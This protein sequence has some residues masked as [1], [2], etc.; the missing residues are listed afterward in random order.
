MIKN[1]YFFLLL[2]FLVSN[3]ISAQTS[4]DTLVVSRYY[5]KADSLLLDR[6]HEESIKLFKQTLPLYEKAMVWEKVASCYNK[7][8]E[9]Y[10]KN[11]DY[12][13]S[14]I[15][16]KLALEIIKKYLPKNNKEEAN[17]YDNMGKCYEK[18]AFYKK[19]LESFEL[20]LKIRQKL[21]KRQHPDFAK[22][23]HSIAIC[24]YR[25]DD[26]NKTIEY[27]KKALEINIATRGKYHNNNVASYN[28]LAIMTRQLGDYNLGLEYCH[29]ALEVI[30]NNK[31]KDSLY[32]SGVYNTIA[33]LYERIGNLNKAVEYSDKSLQIRKKLYD[34]HPKLAVS[35]IINGNLLAE[36]EEYTKALENMD[37]AQ[38]IY[39]NKFGENHP[40]TAEVLHFKG[41]I[42]TKLNRYSDA[43]DY[44]KSG[45]AIEKKY[46]GE[47]HGSTITSYQNIG[48]AYRKK[49]EMIFSLKYY[50]KALNIYTNT[51]GENHPKV[52]TILNDIGEL[53]V[54]QEKIDT[55][56]VYFF[57]AE[58]A[59]FSNSFNPED[60][61]KRE[62]SFVDPYVLLTTLKG[63][64]KCLQK[65]SVENSNLDSLERSISTYNR[66][67]SLINSISKGINNYQDKL[68]FT[69]QVQEIYGSS[70]GSYLIQYRKTG[71]LKALES[72][73]HY[74][75]KSKARTL[76]QILIDDNYKSFKQ[77]PEKL[78][79]LEKELRLNHSFYT[80]RITN[81]YSDKNTDT[82]AIA[83]YE[84]LLF[85]IN[86]KQDS[87]TK[88]FETN[89]PK[90]Y[91]LKYKNEVI[92]LANVQKKLDEET[93][94]LEF[95]VAN[96]NLYLFVIS[97]ND[98]AVQELTIPDLSKRISELNHSIINK[99]LRTY[100]ESSFGLYNE[101]IAPI[102]ENLVGDQ[103]IIIPDGPLWHLNFDLLLTESNTAKA[104]DLPYLLFDY[105]VSY[106]N[107]T[108]LLFN[109]FPTAKSTKIRKACL[110]FSFSDTTGLTNT[111]SVS[112]EKLR[113]STDDLPGTRKE[114]RAIS[115]IINGQY[116]YGLEAVE[117]NFKQNADRFSILHLALHGEVDHEHPQN[118][119]LYFTKNKD[120][121]E[122]NLLY[123]HELFAMDIPADLAVLSACNTGSGTIAKG[124]GIMSLGNAFQYA[125]TKSVL[126]S[127]WDVSDKSAPVLIENFYKN[128]ANNMN[129]A[130]AL[131]Q[132]KV[133]F[134]KTANFEQ[135]APFYWGNFYLLGNSDPIEIDKPLESHFFWIILGCILTAFLVL[136]YRYYRKN[137]S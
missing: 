90:Y 124:E 57:K 117:S 136:A 11:S 127:S 89:Y 45:L 44:L 88:I 101:L 30:N 94:V 53:Y 8:S 111:S 93:T 51:L 83:K 121:V 114:I 4:N 41:N 76:K 85:D 21:Y 26:I 17:A 109:D 28:N 58:K 29:K 7:I 123:N 120:T 103:L 59:N 130:K 107:S 81:E 37:Q 14:N 34:G 9:N 110:A 49:G 10:W 68:A 79:G 69:K 31:K 91:D 39:A 6:K 119:K 102:R 84:N 38:K 22:S 77:L 128:L 42:F 72:A 55:A 70:I 54:D 99:N 66:I 60:K 25:T 12:V 97:K 1:S 56:L 61:N 108:S 125:G 32:L 74:A 92:S 112:M 47:N 13:E 33:G 137:K 19:A 115:N 106:A 75:E 122:D 15:N 73:I 116:F 132:A 135:V 43:I 113:N 16:S 118:S 36:K 50:Q 24:Y 82:V 35:Y 65:V 129:K 78:I 87:L 95:F 133:D 5:K 126:L 18:R 2:I 71:E 27:F 131:R 63:K 40:L 105:A 80:S 67:D 98:V 52:A 20:A 46:F 86:R 104:R 3:I 23:Y 134:L 62:E 96:S 100:K 48:H 64:A